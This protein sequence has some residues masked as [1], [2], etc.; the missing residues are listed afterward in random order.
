MRI[1]ILALIACVS[2][3]CAVDES[4]A[5]QALCSSE[6][7]QNGTCPETAWLWQYTSAYG[8]DWAAN[9][10]QS[11]ANEV[12]LG[13]KSAMGTQMCSLHVTVTDVQYPFTVLITC[14]RER[15]GVVSCSIE[16][17]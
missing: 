16:A 17:G 4:T 9:S 8:Y 2:I 14:I 1:V 3:A 10:Y 13:C 6:D 12:S 5:T 11:A 15:S 7:Q